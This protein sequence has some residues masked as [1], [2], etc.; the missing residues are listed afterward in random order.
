MAIFGVRDHIIAWFIGSCCTLLSIIQS[1]QL[2]TNHYNNYSNP[3]EQ[4]LIILIILM[5]PLFAVDSLI[6]LFDIK[7]SETVI[8]ILDSIKECYESVVIAAFLLLM[9]NLMSINYAFNINSF[10]PNSFITI[11]KIPDALKKH[12]IHQTIPFSLCMNDLALNIETLKKL[13][14]WTIQFVYIRPILSIIC[15]ILEFGFEEWY[16]DSRLGVILQWLISIILNVSVTVAVTA[17]IMFYHAF[18]HELKE[19]RTL[20]KF[21]CIKGVVFFAFWQ[22]ILLQ[23]FEYFGIVH[24][25]IWYNET[26]VAMT[27]QNLL[28]TIEM[29]LL[30]APLHKYAFDFNVYALKNKKNV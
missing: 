1:L 29:G 20:A 14:L 18:E 16:N 8:L 25:D 5:V 23:I 12:T 10:N 19:H 4:Y 15:V 26:Q 27:I 21:L 7:A 3:K 13:T 24:G 17:L 6:G 22:G 30:F 2:I 9:Y 11:N 28:V